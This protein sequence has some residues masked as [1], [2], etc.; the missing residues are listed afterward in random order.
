MEPEIRNT[1]QVPRGRKLS[2]AP[3]PAAKKIK[4]VCGEAENTRTSRFVLEK[5][6]GEER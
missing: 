5:L 4:G 3:G 6:K 1:E 2:K